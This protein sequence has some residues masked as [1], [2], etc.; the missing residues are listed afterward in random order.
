MND[1]L[2][3]LEALTSSGVDFVIVG[4]TAAV[5]HGSA[6][7]TYDLDVLMPFTPENCEGLLAAV[8]PLHPRLSHTVDKRP[9]AFSAEQLTHFKNL[10]LLTDLGRLDVLGSLPPIEDSAEVF[11]T[12]EVMDVAG[13]KVRVVALDL[14]VQVKAAMNRPK[15]KHVETELRAIADVRRSRGK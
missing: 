10:Y 11:R 9:V 13:L 6:M 8:A 2:R 3:L 14:L 7:A 12:A 15:D 1:Y 4:G 5:L